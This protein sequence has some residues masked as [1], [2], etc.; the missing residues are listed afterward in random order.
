MFFG[1]IFDK[2]PPTPRPNPHRKRFKWKGEGGGKLQ[3][4]LQNLCNLCN[5]GSG[6]K[7]FESGRG[8]KIPPRPTPL[9]PLDICWSLD[10]LC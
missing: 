3:L 10:L 5:L 4:I 6:T 7:E 8:K 9:F 1:E 2:S